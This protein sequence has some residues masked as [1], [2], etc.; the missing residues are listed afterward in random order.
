MERI[1]LVGLMSLGSKP[2]RNR[3]IHHYDTYAA[4]NDYNAVFEKKMNAFILFL[5][6]N[7]YN[8]LFFNVGKIILFEQIVHM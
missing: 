7:N 8:T 2:C 6:V 5:A 3:K 1:Q 4:T